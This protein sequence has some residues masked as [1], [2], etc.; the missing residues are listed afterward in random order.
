MSG[1]SAD[2]LLAGDQTGRLYA[3]NAATGASVWGPI[4]LP[5][6]E[7]IEAAPVV[8]LWDFSNASYRAQY[9]PSVTDV[10]FLVA[11]NSSSTTN[12]RVY[13]V[14][15][16][17]GAILW[18][19][20][21]N[22]GFQMDGS[23][24]GA[25]IDA[26][27][28]RLYVATRAGAT[29]TQASLWTLDSLTGDLIGTLSLGHIESTPVQSYDDSTLYVGT[30]IGNVE[31]IDLTGPIPTR[32]W[33]GPAVLGSPVNRYISEDPVTPRRLYL[34]T[35]DGFVWA[36]QDSGAGPPPDPASPL[37]KTAVSGPSAPLVVD[38]TLL[39][40][41]SD[42]RLYELRLA[43]GFQIGQVLVGAG[44]A[45]VGTPSA[46]DGLSAYVGTGSGKLF[47]YLLPLP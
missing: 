16:S 13:A 1:T 42:G 25:W 31:A 19:F 30:S 46:T 36:L 38:S 39:V 4:Q 18:Q 12:N 32:K 7:A 15:L 24:G 3:V 26:T 44:T 20:N 6:A 10:V 27:R 11:R 21:A 43:D 45:I 9:G 8:Q 35:Q 5:G 29:E 28:N 47:R 37:W 40:G 23:I 14:R 41:S 2:Y 34:A 22:G 33:T 17:D